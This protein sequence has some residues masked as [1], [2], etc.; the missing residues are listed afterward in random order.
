MD[1]EARDAIQGHAPKTEGEAY[2]EW[3]L[4]ALREEMLK[5]KRY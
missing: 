4:D 1:P 5:L 2:G 3:P